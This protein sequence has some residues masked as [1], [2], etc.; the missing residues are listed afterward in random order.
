MLVMLRNDWLSGT[1]TIYLNKLFFKLLEHLA[2]LQ[3]HCVSK[4]PDTHIMVNNFHKHRA[5]SMPFDRIVR[6][7]VLDNLP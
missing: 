6:A 5:I 7:T 1:E 2:Y 3:L 4:K